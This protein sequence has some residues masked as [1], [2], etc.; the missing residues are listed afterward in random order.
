MCSRSAGI[1]RTGCHGNVRA[2][3]VAVG[4]SDNPV[5]ISPPLG[6]STC[7]FENPDNNPCEPLVFPAHGK[8]FH[9]SADIESRDMWSKLLGGLFKPDE[10]EAST[11]VRDSGDQFFPWVVRAPTGYDEFL[12]EDSYKVIVGITDDNI[13]GFDFSDEAPNGASWS[14]DGGDPAGAAQQFDD[15]IRTIAPEHFGALEDERNYRYYAI[16]GLSTDGFVTLDPS[17]PVVTD[18]CNDDGNTPSNTGPSHQELA[19]LT[20]GLRYSSCRTSNYDPIFTA[21]AQAVVEGS[22]IPCEFDFPPPPDGEL[23]DLDRLVVT[24]THD[25]GSQA[26]ARVDSCTGSGYLLDYSTPDAGASSE[27]QRIVLCPDSCSAVQ[28]EGSSRINVDFGCI[29]Q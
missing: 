10:L 3:S 6:G 20:G 17:A 2:A 21:I 18:P 27:P 28:A 9:Y 12:R 4:D 19:R 23:L 26:I 7:A 14:F 1:C 8:F 11:S 13:S 5:H 15:A 25:T 16:A 29:G 24:W 22:Q